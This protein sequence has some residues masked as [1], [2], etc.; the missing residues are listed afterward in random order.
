TS[1]N[2]LAIGG[3]IAINKVTN[4]VT[5]E[6]GAGSNIQTFLVLIQVKDEPGIVA[7]TGQIVVRSGFGAGG[8]SVSRTLISAAAAA[9]FRGPGP[10]LQTSSANITIDA[11]VTTQALASPSITAGAA[12]GFF[13]D[14]QAIGGSAV[15]NQISGS[16]AAEVVN[17]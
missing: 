8:A 5:A 16:L 6:V 14:A 17:G 11:N 9:R 12:G 2:T 15:L 7:L 4:A 1:A 10:Q 3:S 13:A